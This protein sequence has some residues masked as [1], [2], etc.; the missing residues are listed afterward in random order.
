MLG[1]LVQGQ[2]ALLHEAFA[3]MRTIQGVLLRVYRSLVHLELGEHCEPLSANRTEMGTGVFAKD[4]RVK[5]A[6]QAKRSLALRT[7]MAA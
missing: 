7:G 1:N 2:T 6:L 3:A 5:A 4:V